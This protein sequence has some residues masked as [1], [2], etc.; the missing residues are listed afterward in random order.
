MVELSTL[1]PE[2]PSI[3]LGARYS[4]RGELASYAAELEALGYIVT[5]RW[6][7]GDHQISDD[8]LGDSE[9]V[10]RLGCRYAME[11]WDDIQA[12]SLCIFF[13]EEPRT[14]MSRGGRHVELGL[15][16]GERTQRQMDIW[17]IGPRE[18]VFHCLLAVEMLP[19]WAD[20]LSRLSELAAKRMAQAVL[21]L[22]AATQEES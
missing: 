6:I 22:A 16:L 18:N 5:S 10:Q 15:A 11:D 9:E 13:T 14:T 21:P 1:T 7:K 3:Y 20:A 4:R 19:T 2:Q 12:A 8:Q 17:A